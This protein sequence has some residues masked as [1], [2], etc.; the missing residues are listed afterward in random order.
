MS[1]STVIPVHVALVDK[2][3][4]Q[5]VANLQEIVGALNASLTGEF[6]NAW[7]VRATVGAWLA[8]TVPP[9]TWQVEVDDTL[10]EPGALGYHSDHHG[11]PYSKVVFTGSD[12]SITIDHEV[13]EMLADPMGSYMHQGRLPRGVEYKY[14]DFGL[15]HNTSYVHYLVE[16]C[17]PPEA[18]PYEVG[19]VLMSDFITRHWYDSK[20]RPGVLYS[21][22]GACKYPRQVLPGGYVSFCVGD[23]WYQVFA[24]KHGMLEVSELG[25]FSSADFRTL[26]EFT[27]HHARVYRNN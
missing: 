2:T 26:R 27:D 1:V 5:R 6:K 13:K 24:D 17:D 4:Q 11:Q 12:T 19:G 18:F 22:T 21:H 8:R 16:V 20:E 7:N 25:Q 14:K 3:L 10:D 9:N 15:R 23:F